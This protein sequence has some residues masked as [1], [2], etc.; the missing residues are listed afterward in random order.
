MD[1]DG[2]GDFDGLDLKIAE[3]GYW[4]DT[5]VCVDAEVWRL[6]ISVDWPW[7]TS[8]VFPFIGRLRKK[9]PKIVKNEENN[10]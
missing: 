1:L 5:P 2:D 6:S 10:D 4:T 8:S 9:F 3:E 7:E